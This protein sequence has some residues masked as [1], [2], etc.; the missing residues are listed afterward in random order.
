MYERIYS[1]AYN[2]C[3]YFIRIVTLPKRCCFQQIERH[4]HHT[5]TPRP[6]VPL[7]TAIYVRLYNKHKLIYLNPIQSLF[8][9]LI[10]YMWP[11]LDVMWSRMVWPRSVSCSNLS[12][13]RKSRINLIQSSCMRL[14]SASCYLLQ[15]TDFVNETCIVRVH[16]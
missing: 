12:A 3:L 9:F 5:H 15:R 10:L 4:Q 7:Y 11:V 13:C 2:S 14:F 1:L 16:K 8:Q 6:Y